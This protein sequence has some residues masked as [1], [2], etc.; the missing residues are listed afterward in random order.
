MDRRRFNVLAQVVRIG[1]LEPE[2][3]KVGQGFSTLLAKVKVTY[4]IY[5]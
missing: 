3:R 1:L 2:N 4:A 5:P